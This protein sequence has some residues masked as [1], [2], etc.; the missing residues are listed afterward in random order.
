M[1]PAL[2]SLCP[3][4]DD[5]QRGH[6]T[7]RLLL[8][9]STRN[10]N[11]VS[12]ALGLGIWA[13]AQGCHPREASLEPSTVQSPGWAM[14]SS[15]GHP[16]VCMPSADTLQGRNDSQL[17]RCLAS[18]TW[19]TRFE[20]PQ[21]PAGSLEPLQQRPLSTEHRVIPEHCQAWPSNDNRT[22]RETSQLL[23]PCKHGRVWFGTF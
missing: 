3:R 4:S 5:E 16:K 17:R 11:W 14:T 9:P 2:L 18:C 23:V 22:K 13:R 10:R 20:Y 21:H 7:L 19:L 1:P 6:P 8:G 15:G 12:T